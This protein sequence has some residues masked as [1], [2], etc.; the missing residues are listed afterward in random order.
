MSS[1]QQSSPPNRRRWVVPGLFALAA[2]AGATYLELSAEREAAPVAPRPA[3]PPAATGSAATWERMSRAE[4]L[5]QRLDL[6][7]KHFAFAVQ[8]LELP[9][10]RTRD[11]FWPFGLSV[12]DIGPAP[13]P[14]APLQ[15]QPWPLGEVATDVSGADLRLWRPLLDRVDYFTSAKFQIKQGD[16]DSDERGHFDARV[17]FAGLARMQD[18]EWAWIR[19]WQKVRWRLMSNADPEKAKSWRIQDWHT[20]ELTRTRTSELLFQDVVDLAVPDPAQREHARVSRHELLVSQ[21]LLTARA[22]GKFEPP[23]EYWVHPSNDRHPGVSVVDIDGDGFDDLYVMDRIG[24]N[25]LLRNRGDGSFEDVAPDLGLD[26]DGLSSSAVFADFDNDGDPDLFLGRT[27]A[28]SM[29]F[30]NVSGHFVDRSQDRVDGPLPKLVSSVNAVDYD[31][32]GLLDVYVST[33]AGTMLWQHPIQ[34]FLPADK[35]AVFESMLPSKQGEAGY[36]ALAGPPNVVLHNTG[37]GRLQVAADP[38]PLESYRN[39][40]QATWADFDA[41]GDPD[42]YLAN[43]FADDQVLR[44]EGGGRFSDVTREL[45]FDQFA[46]GMGASWG[47][48]DRDGRQDVYVSNMYSTAGSR[49]T[50]KLDYLNPRFAQSAQGNFLWHNEGDSFRK[51]S[52]DGGIL[53]EKTGWSWGSQFAD[54]DNDGFLDVVVLNGFYTAPPEAALAGD[55]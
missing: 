42:V 4:E 50:S 47:D 36:M 31:G 44:N 10:E 14:G 23:N 55:T 49:I 53:S 6:E 12:A 30:E 34:T 35:A 51:V 24:R 45:G 2:I 43:D 17:K 11:D 5:I 32:D 13:A 8:N 39:T 25:Q 21:A 29:Y 38:G 9:D 26:V 48:Y 28:S 18:G 15:A 41:D 22:G 16:F 46:L 3:E 7:L 27:L 19:A 1:P 33:Y 52:G 54:L 20:T 40:Y 37:G